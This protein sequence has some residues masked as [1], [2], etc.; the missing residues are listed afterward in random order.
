ME[1][2]GSAPASHRHGPAVDHVGLPTGEAAGLDGQE[3]GHAGDLIRLADAHETGLCRSRLEDHGIFPQGAG[4][5]RLDQAL[6]DAFATDRAALEVF[7]RAAT[8]ADW[9][10]TPFNLGAAMVVL[11]ERGNDQALRDAFS[12]IRRWV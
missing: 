1:N 5:I 12:L 2:A 11:G 7:T 6:K 9:A 10:K 3:Y 8:P 4:K